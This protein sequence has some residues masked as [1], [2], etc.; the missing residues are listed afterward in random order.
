[1]VFFPYGHFIS[2]AGSEL[3]KVELPN[4]HLLLIFGIL[5]SKRMPAST[6]RFLLFLF[7]KINLLRDIQIHLSTPQN[8]NDILDFF[9]RFTPLIC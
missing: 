1:M 9:S 6:G 8:S 4:C 5:S 2:P 7:P 3:Q